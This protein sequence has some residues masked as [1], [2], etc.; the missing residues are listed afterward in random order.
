[1]PSF[2]KVVG[3]S[4]FHNGK[5]ILIE[6]PKLSIYVKRSCRVKVIL[7]NL[8][9]FL[10]EGTD[11]NHF[12]QRVQ[13]VQVVGFNWCGSLPITRAVTLSTRSVKFTRPGP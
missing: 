1:M 2:M 8:C 5:N 4:D 6:I 7:L 9:D 11:L 10:N 12:I 3:N 13:W